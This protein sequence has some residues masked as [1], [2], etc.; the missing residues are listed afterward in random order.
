VSEPPSPDAAPLLGHPDPAAGGFIVVLHD[1]AD[2]DAV[3]GSLAEAH[4]VVPVHVYRSALL[5]FSAA[6]DADALDAVRRHPAVRYVEH[7]AT[8]RMM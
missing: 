6:L 5:G 1:G 2:V 3:L 8:A 4:G 7:D